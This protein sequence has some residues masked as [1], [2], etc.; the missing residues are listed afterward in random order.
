MR[1][2]HRLD[3]RFDACSEVCLGW[4]P[5]Y[6]AE[7]RSV[8]CAPPFEHEKVFGNNNPVHLEIGCGKGRF[9]IQSAVENPDINFLAVEQSR[10]VLV[11]AM[12]S[13]I[14]NKLANLKFYAGKAEYLQKIIPENSIERIYLNFSC[15]FPKDSYA[16]H[17]LTHPLFLKIYSAV[18]TENGFVSQKTDDRKLFEFSIES[19]SAN[20]WMIKNISLDLHNSKIE[21]NII[22]EHEEKFT[23]MGMPI[24][25][26]EAY[27]KK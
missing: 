19:F 4:I 24:Y 23:S 20:N 14:Q 1:R 7:Q 6:I 15:P 2:K 3:E 27:V 11:T 21:G 18:L 9:I 16:K 5:D 22:T 17:R 26:L 8:P 12:E 25:Y 13:A 10:N